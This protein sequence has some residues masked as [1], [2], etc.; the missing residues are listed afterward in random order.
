MDTYRVFI[1]YSHDDKA[2]VENNIVKVLEENGLIPMWDANF[3]PGG[4]FHEQIKNFIAHAHVFMPLITK[5]SIERGWWVN[6]EIG[7][8]M[9]LNIPVLP[10]TQG[11]KPSAMIQQL[12][13]ME[14][15]RN[16]ETLKKQLSKE[17]FAKL[18]DEAQEKCK[19]LF[20]CA[21][22]RE[23]RTP[24]MI[25][26][27][28]KVI[29]LVE[30]IKSRNVNESRFWGGVRQ[31][32]GLTSFH[33]PDKPMS[34]P[35]WKLRYGPLFSEH[36]CL[37]QRK[38][39]QV[40]EK[41]AKE[42]GC[43]FIIYPYLSFKPNGPQARKARL[44]NLIEF[45]ASIENDKVEVAI[46]KPDAKEHYLTIVGDWF[47]AEAVSSTMGEG[48]RQT[49]FTRYAPSVQNRIKSFDD[50][51]KQLLV[52]QKDKNISSREYAINELKILAGLE[53]NKDNKN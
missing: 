18:V 2:F 33:I 52:E 14:L 44:R 13:A 16:Y 30:L 46:S 41:L 6:Q 42:G 40:L 5:A 1:S 11:Q 9:G 21:E 38:E 4:G 19:P 7:Y 50:E 48:I 51:F 12:H 31:K 20:E 23:D 36:R 29:E 32:G 3:S 8:A 45:L 24:M 28:S 49:I 34:H 35:D 47:A 10:V 39:R 53:K 17:G 26:Y 22:Y 25:E 37:Q 27:C 15:S 43:K